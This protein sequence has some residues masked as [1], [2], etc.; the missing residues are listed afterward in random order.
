MDLDEILRVD[1]TRGRTGQLLSPI[2]IIVRM[3]EPANLK[4]E[5]LSK[6]VKHALTQSRLQVTGCTAEKYCLLHVVVQG[7]GSFPDSQVDF[8]VRHTVAELRGVKLAQFSDFGLCRRYMRSTEYPSSFLC[9]ELA[10][11]LRQPY[12]ISLFV[13]YF[14]TS[15]GSLLLY[16]STIFDGA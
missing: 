2:R 14:C 7:P 6:S 1:R 3:P 11:P 15:S 10:D 5:D 4:V 12:A 16:L 9:N 8:S 13:S